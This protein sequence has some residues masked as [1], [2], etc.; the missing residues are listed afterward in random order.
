VL[1]LKGSEMLESVLVSKVLSH[2]AVESLRR[3]SFLSTEELSFDDWQGL[4]AL[5]KATKIHGS[6]FLGEPMKGKTLALVFFNPSLRT[7]VSMTVAVQQL[8]GSAIPLEIGKGTWDLEHL[9]GVLMDGAKSEHV[10][11]AIPVLSQYVDG[12]AVRCFPQQ[13]DFNIDAQDEVLRSIAQYASVPVFNMESAFGHPMQA[14]ADMLTVSE[15]KGGFRK[16]KMVLTWA[17]HPKA[18]PHSVPNSFALATSQCGGDL[19]IVA[20]EGYALDPSVI[21]KCEKF[22]ETMGSSVVVTTDRKKAYEGADIIYAKSWASRRD[23]GFPERED[24]SQLKDWMVTDDVM[25]MTNDA[26]LMHCLP[27]RR[28]VV[29]ADSVLDGPQSVVIQQAA[30]RLHMQR[31]LLA[32]VWAGQ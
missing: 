23:Y 9:S 15:V 21:K 16:R 1:Y 28:N 20:P 12:I 14:L 8:G 4:F 3:K 11:E 2:K 31:A 18:L 17:N 7:R 10:K 24:R 19:W 27:V 6:S 29:V 32:S 5:A 25:K 22:A 26:K 30:N 13:K